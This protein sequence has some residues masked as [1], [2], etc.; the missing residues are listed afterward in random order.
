MHEFADLITGAVKS[1]TS[2]PGDAAGAKLLVNKILDV[3]TEKPTEVGP[4]SKM[5][6]I[7]SGKVYRFPPNEI[8]VKSLSLILT[9]SQPHYNIETYTRDT[10]K[11]GLGFTGRI[12]LDGL[13]RKGELTCQ[14]ANNPFFGGPPGSA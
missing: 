13:Y 2:L 9:D 8:N 3:S 11:F 4:T 10:T 7:I 5:A 12:G 6:A 1:D 14:G